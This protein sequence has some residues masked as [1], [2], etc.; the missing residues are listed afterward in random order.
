MARTVEALL[1]VCQS[2]GLGRITG[3]PESGQR[4]TIRCEN[5]LRIL[6]V[7]EFRRSRPASN[8]AALL[9]FGFQKVFDRL[10]RHRLGRGLPRKDRAHS[11]PC[12]NR[13]GGL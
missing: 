9:E 4:L 6:N 13:T 8:A 1:A 2:A 10:R 12:H 3:Y 11:V 7:G 5:P